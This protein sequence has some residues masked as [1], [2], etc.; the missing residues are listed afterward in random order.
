MLQFWEYLQYLYGHSGVERMLGQAL[1][2]ICAL[3]SFNIQPVLP[4]QAQPN[5][6]NPQP[7]FSSSLT[8][9]NALGAEC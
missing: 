5:P 3:P 2:F 1:N 7:K 4:A 9:L 8:W 6:I